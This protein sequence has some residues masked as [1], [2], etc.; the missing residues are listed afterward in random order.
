VQVDTR[1]TPVRPRVDRAWFQRLKLDYDEPLSNFA[2]NFNLRRYHKYV[3]KLVKSIEV[4][5]CRLP[6]SIPVLKAPTS[7]VS[8]LE[9]TI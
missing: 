7:M 9:T 4:R 1:L 8:A 6:V 3:K 2:F 5:R